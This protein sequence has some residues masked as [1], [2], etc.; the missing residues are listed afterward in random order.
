MR[1]M[2]WDK[3]LLGRLLGLDLEGNVH[4]RGGEMRGRSQSHHL[5]PSL[6]LSPPSPRIHSPIA[7][8]PPTALTLP[9]P[10]PT[11]PRQHGLRAKPVRPESPLPTSHPP[12]PSPT[13]LAPPPAPHRGPGVLRA[14]RSRER[15]SRRGGGGPVGLLALGRSGLRGNTRLIRLSIGCGCAASR[16]VMRGWLG[17]ATRVEGRGLSDGFLFGRRVGLRGGAA[18]AQQRRKPK[19]ADE[20]LQLRQRGHGRRSCCS[21]V[22]ATRSRGQTEHVRYSYNHHLASESLGLLFGRARPAPARARSPCA[23]PLR[24]RAPSRSPGTRPARAPAR[25]RRPPRL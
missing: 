25:P 18:G 3:Q 11:R 7:T 17:K 14:A 8:H 5:P 15:R 10:I 21:A 24:I 23:R 2:R 13:T 20:G 16:R 12:H 6:D 4:K 1:E 22:S 9:S 19:A